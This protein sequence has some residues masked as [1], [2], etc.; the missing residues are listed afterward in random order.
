M[1]FRIELTTEALQDLQGFRKYEQRIIVDSMK[2][3]LSNEP[4]KATRNRKPLRENILSHWELKANRYRIFYD[5]IPESQMVKV[6]AI[7]YKTHN[8][9]FITGKEF[10]I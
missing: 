9:L 10:K 4:L 6:I 3:Q 7:G 2:K 8:T 5:V 1:K